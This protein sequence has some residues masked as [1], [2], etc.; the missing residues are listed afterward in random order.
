MSP[1]DFFIMGKLNNLQKQLTEITDY[2]FLV[3]PPKHE[4]EKKQFEKILEHRRQMKRPY[5]KKT[6]PNIL[7]I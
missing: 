6:K 2:I 3:L 7:T 5:Q 4:D 1:K